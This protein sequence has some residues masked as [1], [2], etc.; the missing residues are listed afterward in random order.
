MSYRLRF[1]QHFDKKDSEAFLSLEKKFIEL[2]KQENELIVARRFVPVSGKEPINTLIWEADVPTMAD[3]TA[4][5]DAI[6]Q[7][8]GHDELLE[9]Q[10]L[11][12]TD[13]YVEIYKEL[14]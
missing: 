1:V 3:V 13:Y 2:E 6:A 10:I 4:L 5:M 14:K 8:A 9:E 12:M 11:Y 7:D